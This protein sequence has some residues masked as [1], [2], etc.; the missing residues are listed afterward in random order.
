MGKSTA[1]KHFALCWAEGAVDSQMKID[2]IFHV[3]LKEVQKDETIENIIIKQHKGLSGNNVKPDEIKAL[4]EEESQKIILLLDG[5][6]EY[7][8]GINENIDKAI[9]K[10]YLRN[11]WIVLTSRESKELSVIRDHM[12][13]EAEITG[14]NQLGREIYISKFLGSEEKTAE[15][16][17]MLRRTLRQTDNV[18]EIPEA[19]EI[20]RI[21]FLVHM[22]CVLYSR[23]ACL[24]KTK[25]GI[26][27]AMVDRCL[28]WEAIRKSGKKREAS[29]KDAVIRLG[30]LAMEGL[31]RDQFH[32]TFT[33]VIPCT[34]KG[35]LLP[36]AR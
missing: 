31:Q 24:P 3:S 16:L 27:D 22:I 14:F 4:L 23:K 28:D 9:T 32:Q 15:L 30:K 26:L 21:P 13:A 11:C 25:T 19:P 33:K 6:D 17:K 18:Y 2:Y 20:L 12:D 7:K 10:D 34:A 36:T 8:C 35:L 5:H 29:V 1:L